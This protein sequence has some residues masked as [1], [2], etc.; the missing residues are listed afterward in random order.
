LQ[1]ESLSLR[2]WLSP[3]PAVYDQR[4]GLLRDLRKREDW[5]G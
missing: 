2:I 3:V 4:Q 5:Q 1:V